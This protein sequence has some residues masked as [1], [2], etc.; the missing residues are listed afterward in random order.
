MN[1]NTWTKDY[2]G[3]PGMSKLAAQDAKRKGYK[4]RSKTQDNLK[5]KP[6]ND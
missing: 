4:P 1:K 2:T 3:S 6:K 5:K